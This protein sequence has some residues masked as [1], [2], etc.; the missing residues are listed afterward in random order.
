MTEP[1]FDQEDILNYG[2]VFEL[3]LRE[4]SIAFEVLDQT[5]QMPANLSIGIHNKDFQPCQDCQAEMEDSNQFTPVTHCV[6]CIPVVTHTKQGIC[7]MVKRKG[8]VLLM[9]LIPMLSE[10]EELPLMRLYQTVNTSLPNEKP[11]GWPKVFMSYFSKDKVVPQDMEEEEKLA[12]ARSQGLAIKILNYGDGRNYHIRPGQLLG[13]ISKLN[14]EHSDCKA[15]Q[16]AKSLKSLLDLGDSLSSY[17]FKKIF[18]S[19]ANTLREMASMA[20]KGK[21]ERLGLFSILNNPE[22]RPILKDRIDFNNTKFQKQLLDHGNILL[23]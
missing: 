4:T 12:T 2:L 15:F 9:D 23:K 11:P 10:M 13:A 20:G 17:L 5:G 8:K 18:L 21:H 19:K 7:V 3:L 6:K 16:Y 22:V 1:L 14:S